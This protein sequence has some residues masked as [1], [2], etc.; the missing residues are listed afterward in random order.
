MRTLH[1]DTGDAGR[2]QIVDMVNSFV[3]TSKR[4]FSGVFYRTQRRYE[5]YRGI[6]TRRYHKHRNNI[7]IPFIYALVQADVANKM[8]TAFGVW[9]VVDFQPGGSEDV[10][11]ARMQTA[12][13]AKQMKDAESWRKAY[14]IFLTSDMYGNAVLQYGW[15]TKFALKKMRRIRQNPMTG[16]QLTFFEEK[17]VVEFNGPQFTDL[18]LLDFY[19]EPGPV[20]LSEMKRVA[21]QEFIDYDEVRELSKQMTVDGKP[22]FDPKGV[23]ELSEADAT[24]GPGMAYDER[25]HYHRIGLDED[26]AIDSISRPV[27]LTHYHGWVP[28]EYADDG[29]QIRL[30]TVGN[31]KAL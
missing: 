18:D 19:P 25:R 10:N 1:R 23:K 14:R 4:A 20:Y 24:A 22:Y 12:L 3:D 31:G 21:N 17:E 9:P 28:Q 15:D 13:V 26:E 27:K 16:E 7:N 2:Q 8:Q 5:M 29:I 11:R 30:V 6:Q